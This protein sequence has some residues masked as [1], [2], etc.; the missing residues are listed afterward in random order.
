MFTFC[1]DWNVCIMWSDS[2][3]RQHHVP[4]VLQISLTERRRRWTPVCVE[5]KEVGLCEIH[6]SSQ[7]STPSLH[8]DT[9][10]AEFPFSFFMLMNSLFFFLPQRSRHITCYPSFWETRSV[11][12]DRQNFEVDLTTFLVGSVC[13]LIKIGNNN[14]FIILG[15]GISQMED[16]LLLKTSNRVSFAPM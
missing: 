3:H 10:G 9:E 14:N 15:L 1:K 7:V 2:L 16:Q 11:S 6:Q 12:R 4:W 5:H 13:R 8:C